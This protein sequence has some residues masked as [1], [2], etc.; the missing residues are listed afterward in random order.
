MKQKDNLPAGP[1]KAPPG[2]QTQLGSSE[3]RGILSGRQGT[4]ESRGRNVLGAR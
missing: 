3:R 2:T 1:G 4:Q